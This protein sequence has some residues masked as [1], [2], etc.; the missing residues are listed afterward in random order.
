MLLLVIIGTA[1][2]LPFRQPVCMKAEKF[3]VLDKKKQID[4]IKS[5]GTFLCLRQQVGADVILYQIDNFYVE[6]FFDASE[7]GT[8]ITFFEGTDGLDA[9]LEEVDIAE[10]Q[11]LL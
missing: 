10:L 7:G 4:I 3:A 8:T 9:Y 1:F 2:V 5:E 6:V 11:S